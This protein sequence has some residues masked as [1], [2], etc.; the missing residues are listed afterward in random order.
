MFDELESIADFASE[1][2]R[3]DAQFMNILYLNH[4]EESKEFYD[5][6]YNKIKKRDI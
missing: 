2:E 4:N 1:N 5:I 3:D 6:A